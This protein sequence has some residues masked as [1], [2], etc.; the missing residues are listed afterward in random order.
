MAGGPL[1]F[2]EPRRG[3]AGRTRIP[4]SHAAFVLVWKSG[5]GTGTAEPHRPPAA[6][7]Y[8]VTFTN[9]APYRVTFVLNG[10]GPLSRSLAVEP[11]HSGTFNLAVSRVSPYVRIRQPDGS[12]Q[13][14][15]LARRDQRYRFRRTPANRVVN[16][17]E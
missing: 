12:S 2:P 7:S 4:V 15:A 16:I 11:G 13:D 3:K 6:T 10:S 1:L 9:D 17:H 14:F 8:A 5:Q